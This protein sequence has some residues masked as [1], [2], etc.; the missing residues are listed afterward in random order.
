VTRLR[1]LLVSQRGDLFIDS[2]FGAVIITLIM[3]AAGSV[4]MAATTAATGSD[5]TTTRSILL[6]TVL[7]DEKP[8]LARYTGTPQTIT[9]TVRGEDV[10]IAIW[11]ED[12]APGMSVLNA[13]TKK[14]AKAAEG[15]DCAG[16]DRLDSSKCLTSRTTV[17]ASAGGVDLKTVTLA[18]GTSGALN[19]FAAPAAATELRYVFKVTEAT[20]DSTI[21]FGNR[22]HP[23]V[24]H[25]VKIPAGQTGYYYGRVL[26]NGSAKLFLQS[27][28]PAIVDA[29]SILIYEAPTS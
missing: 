21:T 12:P 23:D 7:S 24:T 29:A 6:N 1:K 25:I 4:L 9:R 26:V 28:G 20:A 18:P 22:D 16:T 5:T 15:A 11:R 8:N 3:A 17:T 27:S 2:M 10:S 14:P 19:D 13:A